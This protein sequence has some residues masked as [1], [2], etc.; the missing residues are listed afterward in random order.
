M[1]LILLKDVTFGNTLTMLLLK[2]EKSRSEIY[3]EKCSTSLHNLL[4]I[5]VCSNDLPHITC[6]CRDEANISLT[7]YSHW[8]FH[9]TNNTL[10]TLVVTQFCIVLTNILILFLSGPLRLGFEG[11]Q[12]RPRGCGISEEGRPRQTRGPSSDESPAWFQRSKDRHRR[13]ACIPGPDWGSLPSSGRTS[14]TLP[15][16]WKGGEAVD[17]GLEASSRGQLH[18]E[19]GS[20]GGALSRPTFSVCDW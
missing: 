4:F 8:L 20:T 1:K 15:R 17:I 7:F 16:L 13:H 14:S 2:C 9:V 10:I 12:V 5:P 6:N 18:P 19:G 3:Y 11:H